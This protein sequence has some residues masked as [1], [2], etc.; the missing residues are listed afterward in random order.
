MTLE[1]V[2]YIS[3]VFSSLALVVSLIY[4]GK[5]ISHSARASAVE[6]KLAT[7][8]MLSEIADMLIADHELDNLLMRA[9]ASADGLTKQEYH[10][11]SNLCLKALWFCSAAHFQ[12]RAG[13]LTEEDWF[14]L[15]AILD[16]WLAGAGFRNWWRRSGR[17]RFTGKFA[18]FVDAEIVRI[19]APRRCNLQSHLPEAEQSNLK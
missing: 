16:F 1:S 10:R 15:K 9:M 14:E 17:A 4:L 7:T 13:T 3:Q 18:E 12:L 2:Y 19:E 8:A 6:A 5:Q 11:F